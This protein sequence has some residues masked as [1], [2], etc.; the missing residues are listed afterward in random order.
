MWAFQVLFCEMLLQLSLQLYMLLIA[1]PDQAARFASLKQT[2]QNWR[3]C[4]W[5]I[6]CKMLSPKRVG[7]QSIWSLCWGVKELNA[8]R[9]FC[10]RVG[11]EC[12]AFLMGEGSYN[13]LLQLFTQSTSPASNQFE[14]NLVFSYLSFWKEQHAPMHCAYKLQRPE[15]GHVQCA[16]L[17]WP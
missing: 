14:W 5:C 13:R 2:N 4:S 10:G 15:F 17:M 12:A 11:G 8:G 3:N 9:R 1:F 7:Q 16:R 6:Y